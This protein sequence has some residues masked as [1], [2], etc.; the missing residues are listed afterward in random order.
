VRGAILFNGNAETEARLLEA[1]A[2]LLLTSRHVDPEVAASKRVV[3]VTAGWGEN[4]HDEGHVKRALNDLGITSDFE[5]GYDRRLV[6]LSLWGELHGV[7]QAAPEIRDAWEE[8]RQ[9]SR[10]ARAFYLDHNAHLIALF[11]RALADAR[12]VDP[13][14]SVSGL[15]AVDV[16][17]AGSRPLLR[18][19]L[20]RELRQALLTLEANDDHLV[21][22]LREIER[23]TF[24]AAGVT[25]APGWRAARERLESR[26]LSASSIVLFGGRLDL[27]LDALRFFRLREPMAEALRRGALFVAMSAGAMVLCERVIVYD[28]HAETRRDFQLYDRGLSLVRDLQLFPHC[29]ERIQTDDPDNLA[30]LARRFR[31]HVCVGLN[32][33]SFLLFELAARR[34]T[35][36][37]TEDGVYVFDPE[38]RKIC[39]RAGADIPVG[40]PAASRSRLSPLSR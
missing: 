12:E 25:Y 17:P 3:L 8:L 38:G 30:Y 26:I 11:R 5:G 36:Q 34:A 20:G 35:S 39:Y 22:L 6:N 27:L 18:Y 10:T 9:V 7:F 37:G 15:A 40:A 14:L 4:E 24:D 1:A 19:A 16:V 23:R 33:R 2:P 31:H 13:D 21:D 32:E 28:D 29:M